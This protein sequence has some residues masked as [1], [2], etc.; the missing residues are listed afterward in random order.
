MHGAHWLER[1]SVTQKVRVLSPGEAEFSSQGSGAARCLLMKHICHEAG[2]LKKVQLRKTLML[3]CDS[4]AGR[5][6]AQ[7]LGAV[8][9]RNI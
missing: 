9:C 1:W 6:T 2:E 5:G 4:V 7:K 8:K 3:H